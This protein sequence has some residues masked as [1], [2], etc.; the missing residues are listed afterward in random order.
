MGLVV[1]WGPPK[2]GKSFWTFDLAMHVALGWEYRGRRVQQGA[3]VYLALEGG[4]GFEARIEAFRQRFLPENHSPVPFFLIADALNL[5]KDHPDL[6]GCI[7]VQAQ[8]SIPAVVVIDTLNRSLAGSESDDKDMT[9][10]IRAADAIRNAFGC[11][12]IVVHHCGVDGTRPRGHTSLAG[13]VDAQ[14]AVKRDPAENIIV[15]VERMK[16]GAEGDSL[17]SKLETV[18]VGN[19]IDGDAI[20]SCVVVPADGEVAARSTS[21]KLSDRQ[22]LALDVLADRSTEIGKPPPPTLGLPAGLIAIPMEDWRNGLYAR[23]ILDRDAKSPR[24]DF[25]RVRNAL[26]TRRLIGVQD[27]LVWRA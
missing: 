27:D 1:A 13:A 10:Y 24:E 7:R 3:V 4:K 16:D 15:T 20:V 5:V 8:G 17:F 9:A 26:Q 6:I 23:G 18:E 21:R 12:V 2:C 14:L 25:R 11:V 19:D 22:R